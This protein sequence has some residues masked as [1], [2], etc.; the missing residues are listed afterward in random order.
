VG[1]GGPDHAGHGQALKIVVA[2]GL[3]GGAPTKLEIEEAG[4][5][6]PQTGDPKETRKSKGAALRKTLV[7]RQEELKSTMA[8]LGNPKAANLP[9]MGGV[10]AGDVPKAKAAPAKTGGT[11]RVREKAS[12]KVKSLPADQAQSV[13]AD[14]RFE[15]AP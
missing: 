10:A 15:Q 9:D 14:P 1:S 3:H 5:Y 2:R 12:G 11:V 13:L 8:A 4:E 7:D 6:V